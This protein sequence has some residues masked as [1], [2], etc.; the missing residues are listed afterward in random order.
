[1]T[2]KPKSETMTKKSDKHTADKDFDREPN[3]IKIGSFTELKSNFPA[4]HIT[5]TNKLW[6]INIRSIGGMRLV[7]GCRRGAGRLRERE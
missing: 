4:F 1:M 7:K 2:K 3:M 5:I 6:I